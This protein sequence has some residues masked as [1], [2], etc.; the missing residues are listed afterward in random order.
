MNIKILNPN[1]KTP[2]R[3]TTNAAGFDLVAAIDKPVSVLPGE[4]VRIGTG[5]AV[6]FD[7]YDSFGMV[8]IRSGKASQGLVLVNG[9][10]IIDADYRGEIKL[11]IGNISNELIEIQPMTRIAQLVVMPFIRQVL[12]SVNALTQTE[13]GEGGFGSTG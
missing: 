8:A 13:R 1:V 10:G 7:N 3:Q 5:I 11:I 4:I 12:V 6:E 9:V 2:K